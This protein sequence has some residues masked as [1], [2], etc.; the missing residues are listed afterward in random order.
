MEAQAEL[1]RYLSSLLR[2]G[3]IVGSFV[4]TVW[5]ALWL[6]STYV[7]KTVL[8]VYVEKSLWAHECQQENIRDK[9]VLGS[10]I[11]IFT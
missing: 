5:R 6:F 9:S 7:I 11:I 10:D 3:S 1:S 4:K 8:I 2:S